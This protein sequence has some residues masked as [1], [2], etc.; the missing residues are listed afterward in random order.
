M[1][2][3]G[4]TA[5]LAALLNRVAGRSRFELT[6]P[7]LVLDLDI[8]RRNI[9]RMA[10]YLGRNA[11]AL[12]PH[13]KVH[14]SSHLA[15]MQIEAGALGVTT[16][17]V[18]EAAAMAR[19]GIDDIL[20][21]NQVVGAGQ[22][23]ALI[24]VAAERRVIVAVDDVGNV[25]QLGAAAT[26]AG[27]ALGILV[28]VDTGMGR[29]G[30]RTAEAAVRLSE[31]VAETSGLRLRGVSGYEGHCML[32]PDPGKRERDARAAMDQLAEAVAA[33][34]STSLACEI[35]SAGGTGTYHVTGADARVT[36]IQAGS[37]AL[38]DAFHASLVPGGFEVALTVMASVISRR[39]GQIV[40]DAG[41]K[42]VGIDNMLPTL[43]GSDA[44][45]R[46]V[47]EEHSGFAIPPG[48]PLS[49]GDTVELLA[50]YAPTT[51]NL[52]DLYHVVA[53][54]VVSDL[55]PVEAR[56]GTASAG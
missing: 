31:I 8:A 27:V 18:W 6:T 32:E 42:A 4:A 16:A 17:T 21:A 26:R 28:E 3:A 25:R 56:Y 20:V 45:P 53:D 35:V 50:G 22:V 13:V 1:S 52:Y 19:A 14:K 34:R 37:Y 36:E 40:L 33:I 44:E 54:G 2:E 43:M 55:W 30:V 15:R 24:R 51:V 29:A 47:H 41:R 9:A 39:D 23:E 49:V 11:T 12:R 10:E 5:Q 46:F 48:S 7:A 38:M